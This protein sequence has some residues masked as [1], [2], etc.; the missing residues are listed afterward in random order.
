[1]VEYERNFEAE[2]AI[3]LYLKSVSTPKYPICY[4]VSQITKGL[5]GLYD[6]KQI[7]S[8]LIDLQL[9]KIVKLSNFEYKLTSKAWKRR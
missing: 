7:R 9:N 6:L 1:M 8:S 3:I 4:S 5:K 2:K